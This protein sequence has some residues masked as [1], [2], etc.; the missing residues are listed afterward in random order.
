MSLAS[1]ARIR[2]NDLGPA[3]SYLAMR[4]RDVRVANGLKQRDLA[5]RMTEAGQRIQQTGIAKIE[6]GLR[7]VEVDDLMAL[8]AALEVPV[9]DLLPVD[10]REE[11]RFAISV[12][13]SAL[14]TLER[15]AL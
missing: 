10:A 6:A 8:S 14:D 4:V 13:R 11:S 12:L 5:D 2:G 3:G 7:R 1:E 9:T 15:G